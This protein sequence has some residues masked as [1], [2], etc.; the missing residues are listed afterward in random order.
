[1]LMFRAQKTS[2]PTCE[3]LFTFFLEWLEAAN[4][5]FLEFFQA[6]LADLAL[7]GLVWN[8]KGECG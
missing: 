8:T 5:M 6:C 1:M 3:P 4:G 2:Q 7:H